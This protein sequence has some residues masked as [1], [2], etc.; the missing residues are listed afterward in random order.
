MVINSVES[1]MVSSGCLEI[2]YGCLK[3]KFWILGQL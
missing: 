1:K 2:K 3:S